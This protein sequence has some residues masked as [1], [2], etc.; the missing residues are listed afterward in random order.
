M[1]KAW[2]V[3]LATGRLRNTGLNDVTPDL[4]RS[5]DAVPLS[6]RDANKVSPSMLVRVGVLLCLAKPPAKSYPGW[7][8]QLPG[9]IPRFARDGLNDVTPGLWPTQRRAGAW[10]AEQ[11]MGNPKLKGAPVRVWVVVKEL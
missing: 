2:A 9:T 7:A 1:K 6:R 10:W 11:L 8:I 5:K 3:K 4:Y